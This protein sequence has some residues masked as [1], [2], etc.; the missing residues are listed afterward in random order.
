MFPVRPFFAV[1]SL[2][3]SLGAAAETPLVIDGAWVRAL[4]P[5]QPNTAAYLTIENPGA[6]SVDIV[7]A[8]SAIAERVQIHTSREV[9]GYMRMEQLAKLE[10]PA[11]QSLELA[12][13]GIHL[14]LLGLKAMP[15]PGEQVQLCLVTASGDEVCLDAPV[16]KAADEDGHEHHHHQ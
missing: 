8:R 10:V 4:P 13:G 6:S 11:G 16:R 9:D 14:M 1:L 15:R 3:F 12:P 5:T 2:A 7:A